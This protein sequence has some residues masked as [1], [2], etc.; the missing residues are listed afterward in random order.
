M[1]A[2]PSRWKT[3][4]NYA[5]ILL[6]FA[7]TGTTAAWAPRLLMPLTGLEKG[8]WAYIVV[9]FV[10]ITPIYQVLL[11]IYAF[12]F[13]RFHYFWSKQKLLFRKLFG[14]LKTSPPPPSDPQP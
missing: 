11:L 10:L 1:P 5:I 6:I 2:T 4:F 8:T 13:G 12:I 14:W 3:I 9:Y 7:L